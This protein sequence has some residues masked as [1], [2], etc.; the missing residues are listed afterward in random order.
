MLLHWTIECQRGDECLEET[1]I[2]DN[3]LEDMEEE[4]IDYLLMMSSMSNKGGEGTSQTK[5]KK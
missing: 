2:N 1:S 4:R 5:S 3:S